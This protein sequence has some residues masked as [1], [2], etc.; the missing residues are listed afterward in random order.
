[1]EDRNNILL[2]LDLE[3]Y[4]NDKPAITT[5]TQKD[6]SPQNSGNLLASNCLKPVKFRKLVISFE[7]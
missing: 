2:V 6:E 1:M 4:N 7:V 5:I 3:N